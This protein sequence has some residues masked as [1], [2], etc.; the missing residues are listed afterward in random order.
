MNCAKYDLNI[1]PDMNGMLTEKYIPPV[2]SMTLPTLNILPAN[3]LEIHIT[4]PKSNNS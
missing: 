3:Q 4:E 2:A 1:I